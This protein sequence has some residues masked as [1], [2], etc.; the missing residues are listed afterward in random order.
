MRLQARTQSRLTM[1]LQ[2]KS[3]PPIL[4]TPTTTRQ[5]FDRKKNRSLLSRDIEDLGQRLED[6]GN[7]T[8]TQIE[9]NKK[10]EA[11]LAK[12]K[13]DLE[14]SNIAHEGTLAALRQKHNNNMAELGE[15]ID[16]LNK[17]K[18]KSEKDKSG[19]ERDLQEARAGLDE[20]MRERANHER[21]G[22]LTQGLI[23]EAHQKLDEMARALNEADST[24]KKLQVENQDLCRQ[25]EETENAIAALSKNKI[26]LTT[27]LEDTKRL[28]DAEARDRASLLT[29]FKNLNTESENLRERIE[30]E[31]EKKNDVLR[32]LSKAQAEIQL[33]KSKFETEG[34]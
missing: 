24:K 30:E 23:V 31:A 21:N 7:N 3:V 6:A 12:L 4:V 29:K 11:E 26:S 8:A 2:H 19:M 33:W 10:R 14:E 16:G 18:A 34:F 13:G 9:L 32:A 15:Q 5:L 25:I 28:G 20:V 27:Q 22:K 1:P 17:N